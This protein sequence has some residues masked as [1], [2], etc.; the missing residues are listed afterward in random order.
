MAFDRDRFMATTY[1]YATSEWDDTRRWTLQRLG[2]VASQNTTITCGDLCVA[3]SKAG[4]L[5][6]EPHSTALAG[7]L[8]QVNLAR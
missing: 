5:S 1:G 3:M 2:T 6:L 7:L 8:G 4:V